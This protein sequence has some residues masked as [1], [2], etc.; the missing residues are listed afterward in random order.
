[1]ASTGWHAGSTSPTKHTGWTARDLPTERLVKSGKPDT[2]G[3]AMSERPRAIGYT[4]TSTEDQHTRPDDDRARIEEW[5]RAFDHEL[6]DVLVDADVSG[7]VPLA[8][9]PRGREID[10]LT[11]AK[12]PRADTL[13]VTNLDRLGRDSEDVIGLI[14][15]LTPNGGRRHYVALVAL[16]QHLDLA[17]PFG[18]F[19]AKQFALFAELERTMI[20]WRTG[21]ALRHKR[22]TGQVYSRAPYGWDRDGDQLVRNADEQRVLGLMRGWREGGVN[23]HVIAS[24]LNERGEPGK[25]GGRWQ[26]NT[27]F[28]ILQHADEIA[29]EARG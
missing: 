7:K 2:G 15:R 29:A 9:R 24:R 3:S 16:D 6:L 12:R 20:G 22:R 1:V 26:A 17:G 27:V 13:V 4:R 5:C 23:D 11:R 25:R 14:N 21:N 8:E 10:A 19:M 28:R 18:P